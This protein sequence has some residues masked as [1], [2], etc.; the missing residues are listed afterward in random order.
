MRYFITI[1]FLFIYSIVLS[2]STLDITVWNCKTEKLDSVY[3]LKIYKDNNLFKDLRLCEDNKYDTIIANLEKG[4]YIIEYKSFFNEILF[5]TTEIKKDTSY[6]TYLCIDEIKDYSI[7]Y[8]GIIDSISNNKEIII[9][10]E[11]YGCFHWE[12]QQLKIFKKDNQYFATLY[13]EIKAGKKARKKGKKKT[14]QLSK[15]QLEDLAELQLLSYLHASGFAGGTDIVAYIYKYKNNTI[16]VINGG[17]ARKA[18]ERFYNFIKNIYKL[19]K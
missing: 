7:I 8:K 11:S 19:Q 1:T 13:P 15:E 16:K 6:A 5:D 18:R 3:Y 14:V 10:L 4:V 2:Q 12:M 17:D 9:E